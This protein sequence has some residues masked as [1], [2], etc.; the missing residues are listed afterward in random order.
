MSTTVRKTLRL[1]AAA[2]LLL[3]IGSH[4]A[5]AQQITI[6]AGSPGG[7]YFKAAAA[8][9]EYIK[10]EIP[11]SQTTVIPG[12]G[13]AN[14]ERLESGLADVAVLENA[15]VTQATTGASPDGRKYDFRMLASFRGPS[16][17]QAAIV[18]S[19]GI[20]SFEQIAER[21]FPLRVAMIQPTQ[22]VT[23]IALDI[24]AAYGITKEAIEA[25]GGQVIYTSQND[26]FNMIMDGRADM[27]FNGGAFYPH[28]KYIELGTKKPFTVLPI[29]KAVAEQ[30]ADKYGVGIEEVPA[31]IYKNDN[32]TN[33]AYWSPTLVVVLAARKDLSD[34]LAHGVL[35]ALATH[36][37]EFWKVNPHHKYFRPEVAWQNTGRA[38]LHPGAARYY[39]EM[40]YMK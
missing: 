14:I 21:K 26:G 25:W 22:I 29:S 8:V 35:K 37:E 32:G 4:G 40:G 2:G 16:V 5:H 6:T 27:W 7:G 17:A 1:A 28:H 31:D 11:G 34:A 24:L 3:A 39:R 38:P 19:T 13:W 36:K 9:A 15:I 33:S 18:N 20:T 12:G 30:V 23:P 10:Q